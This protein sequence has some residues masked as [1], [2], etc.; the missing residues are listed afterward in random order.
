LHRNHPAP[1]P[2]RPIHVLLSRLPAIS[3]LALSLTL[4]L[5]AW[6]ASD[7]GTLAAAPEEHVK[8]AIRGLVS[9]GAFKFVGSGGDPVNTLEPIKAKPGIFG[10]L[11]V[12]ASWAQLQPTGDTELASGNVIDKAMAEVRAYNAAHPE[13]PLAVRLRIWGGF[14]AP[15]WV[16][17]LG[18]PPIKAVH[19]KKNRRVG[20]FWSPE[21][22]K[23]WARLQEKLAAKYDSWPLIR[24]VSVTSCMSFTAEPFF[25]PSEDSVQ[26]PIRD[27][28]FTPEA[29]KECLSHALDDYAAWKSSRLVLSVNPL[30]TGLNQGAGDPDFTMNIMRDCRKRLGARCVFDNHNLDTDL[31]RPLRPLYA[32]M[33]ELGPEIAYQT[34]G[35]NPKDFEGTIKLGVEQGATSIELWQDY[36]GFPTV[37]DNLLKRWA[38]MIEAN[39]A[40]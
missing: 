5:A 11:V 30:R 29:Y 9:M 14:K 33:K 13:K 25:V 37:P 28:G 36:G 26:Q 27:A 15:D 6:L 21:Y 32:L 4:T 39:R 12:I 20:R 34:G 16:L 17:N 38:A 1:H 23:A 2:D 3:A 31:P 35:T 22:R 10:G 40:R 8:P 7:S 18:G 24:E 19:N